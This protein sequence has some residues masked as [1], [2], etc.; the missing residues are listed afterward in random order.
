MKLISTYFRSFFSDLRNGW[1]QF[2]FSPQ[3]PATLSLIRI[4]TGAMLFYTHLVWT[5]HSSAFFGTDSW[6]NPAAVSATSD[7]SFQ[8]SLLWKV[9]AI[10]SLWLMH[11]FTL[12]ACAALMVGYQTRLASICAWL[13]TVSY[14]HRLPT[15]LYGLDQ[16]NGFLS[17]YLMFGKSGARYSVDSWLNRRSNRDSAILNLVHPDI[18]TN[19]SIRLI[20]VHLC[21]LYFFAGISKLQGETWWDGTALWGA[22]ANLEYQT[23]DLTWMVNHPRLINLLTHVTIVWEVLYCA[24]IWNRYSKPFVLLMA[25]P[26]H[27]GI[28]FSFGMITFGLIMLVANAAFIPPVLIRSLLERGGDPTLD[29]QSEEPQRVIPRPKLLERRLERTDREDYR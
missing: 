8:W 11:A 6:L 18:G 17:M 27:L 12:I 7:S 23:I 25:V 13:M 3:D 22:I 16:V 10:G 20:Q 19:I 24:A 4:A 29:S 5:A 9:E 26:V 28:A 15:A 14:A 21:V 1:N 2:W